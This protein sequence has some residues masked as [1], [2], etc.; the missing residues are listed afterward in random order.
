MRKITGEIAVMSFFGESFK[1]EKVNG[2]DINDE[3]TD[4]F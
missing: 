1:N 4:I 2:N 3:I